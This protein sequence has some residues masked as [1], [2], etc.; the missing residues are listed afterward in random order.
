FQKGDRSEPSRPIVTWLAFAG[1]GAA[2]IANAWLAT[3]SEVGTTGM[4]AVD[5]FRIFTNYLLL[6]GGALFVPIS[7]RYLE[8]EHLRLGEV[9]ALVLLSLVGMMVFAGARDL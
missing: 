3:V 8:Q 2:A 1:I 5:G 6:L 9:Y 4:I 7:T